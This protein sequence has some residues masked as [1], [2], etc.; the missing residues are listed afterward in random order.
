MEPHRTL[1]HVPFHQKPPRGSGPPNAVSRRLHSP[2]A[3]PP[4][5]RAPSVSTP[6]RTPA[7]PHRSRP[8]RSRPSFLAAHNFAPQKRIHI[9]ANTNRETFRRVLHAAAPPLL[10]GQV[11]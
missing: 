1:F 5:P 2:R 10:R 4:D 6:R 11:K 7:F 8:G 9:V 3:A